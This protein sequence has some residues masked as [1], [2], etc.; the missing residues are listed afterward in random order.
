[1]KGEKTFFIYFKISPYIG[2]INF[3]FLTTKRLNNNN[4][5]QHQQT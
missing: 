3:F 1:M 2:K 5:H 4:K